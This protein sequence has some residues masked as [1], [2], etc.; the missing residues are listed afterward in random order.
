MDASD[1]TP[2]MI[3]QSHQAIRDDI[4]GTLCRF[5]EMALDDV[6]DAVGGVDP[7]KHPKDYRVRGRIAIEV[8]RKYH[9]AK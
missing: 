7:V 4:I 6:E 5:L 2:E 1:V 9:G 3:E 8:A